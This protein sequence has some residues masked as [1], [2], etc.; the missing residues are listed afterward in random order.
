[1]EL[2]DKL[3]RRL[4]N[5]LI[6][7][8]LRSDACGGGQHRAQFSG[9]SGELKEGL[10]ILTPYG[11]AVRFLPADGDA[12]PE[13][14]ILAVEPDLRYALPPADRRYAPDDLAPGE[15]ALYTDED[16][17]G[18]CRLHFKRGRLVNLICDTVT[19]RADTLVKVEAPEI[20][21]AAS[22]KLVLDCG[23]YGTS[24]TCAGG[25][26]VVDSYTTGPVTSNSHPVSP[27]NIP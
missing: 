21:L 3:Q 22:H 6:V 10:R 12:G 18:G 4:G 17:S 11:F 25:A 19:V 15:V 26:W 20:R 5:M 27:P 16:K 13:T 14:V 7:A 9:R 23:G 2:L 8:V 1:M 24:W